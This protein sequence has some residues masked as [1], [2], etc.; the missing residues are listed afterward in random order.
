MRAWEAAKD[1]NLKY[2][3]G[4]EAYFVAD[5]TLSDDR[6]AH[7]ILLAKNMEGVCSINRALAEAN[8]TGFYRYP[9]VDIELLSKM[10]PRDVFVT[11][12]CVAH[13]GRVDKESGNLV[14]D[15]DAMRTFRFLAEHFTSSSLRLEVQAHNTAWQKEVNSLCQRLSYEYHIPLIAGLDSHYIFPEGFQERK[16]LRE[17]SGVHMKDEDHEIDAAVYEDYPDDATVIERFRQQGVLTEQEITS[18]MAATDELLEFEDIELSRDRK[19]PTVYPE[20][21]Q[22]ERNE[23]YL[24]RV[25]EGW[26]EYRKDIPEERWPEY[27]EAIRYETGIVT[28]TGVA[29]YFLITNDFVKLGVEKY[30]GIITP[31]GRGSSGGFFTNT[32]LGFSTLDRVDLPVKLY[33]ERFVTAERLKSSLPDLDL[34]MAA[35][36][37]FIAAMEE[38]MGKNHV[39]PMISYNTLKAKAAFKLYA[40]VSGLPADTAN[41]VSKQI[42]RYEMALKNAEEDEQD[43]IDIA[44]YVD[45]EYIPY[46]EKSEPYRGIVVS[47]S[48][49]PCG[50]LLY[51]GDIEADV[52]IVRVNTGKGKAV[53]CTVCDGYCLEAFGYVKE[54]CLVVNVLSVNAEAMRLAG[55]KPL[56]SKDVIR[57]VANDAP[58]WGV[59]AEG[60]TCGINQCGGASTTEKLKKYRPRELRDLAAFIAAIRPGFKSQLNSFLARERFSYHIAPFD[61]VLQNDSSGSSWMLYQENTMTALNLAGFSMERTYPIIKAI[62]KKKKK[63][64]DAA[65]EEFVLGFSDYVMRHVEN[66]DKSTADAQAR[67]TWRVIK[68][69]S[70]YSFN[71]CVTGDTVLKRPSNKHGVTLN[72]KDMYLIKNDAHYANATGHRALHDKYKRGGYGKG[73]S[74]FDD[75]RIREN[76]IVDIRQAG[77]RDVYCITLENGAS[78]KCT[79]NHKFPTPRGERHCGELKVGDLLYLCG[80]YEHDVFDSTLTDGSYEPNYPKKG[81]C[82]FREKTLGA[83]VLFK[84]FRDTAIQFSLPCAKCGKPYSDNDRFEVHHT[85]MDRHHNDFDNYTWLC[86]SCH[87]KIHYTS[88]RRK[89]GEKGYPS[90]TAT[91]TSIEYAGREMTYDVEMNAPAHNFTTANGIVTS[92]SHAVAVALDALYGAYLKAHYPVAY[93]TALLTNY[94]NKG[95]AEMIARIKQEMRSGFGIRMAPCRFRQDNRAYTF[96]AEKKTITD[97]LHAMKGVGPKVSDKLYAMRDIRFSTFVDALIYIRDKTSINSAVM[98]TLIRSGYFEEFGSTNRLLAVYAAFYD[99]DIH[100]DIKYVEKTKTARIAALKELERTA[101]DGEP[102]PLE[103]IRFEAEVYGAPY[104]VIDTP[105]TKLAYVVT[106]VQA[107]KGSP[108]LTLY[109][110]RT[111]STQVVKVRKDEFASMPLEVGDVMRPGSWKEKPQSR[112]VDGKW[113]PIP[114][115]REWWFYDYTKIS[116]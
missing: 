61:K 20:L 78:I 70:S 76:D 91:I 105:E 80:N 99:G 94:A 29:D 108:R 34:N 55:L 114:N 67:I 62:S 66:M 64:I 42:D 31:T 106:D 69:S 116:A 49:A 51:D 27:E 6:N 93:Y 98:N 60:Y 56:T 86:A 36:E 82:G 77:V 44:D 111:G 102:T 89:R 50:F 97:V 103:Q 12:A 45:A 24:E 104:S 112:M 101:E 71:A 92:N 110:I 9:R 14:M 26:E 35:Q 68:D 81:E 95:D 73:Y 53:Y 16:W 2:I 113:K 30:G 11:T 25:R 57:L 109:S 48:Q 13:W 88:G 85:D 72:I 59:F 10:S 54:D 40:R 38:V 4:V 33:P 100:Y 19:L 21:T 58:T 39:Y 74:L 75:G 8:R 84:R 43:A 107:K 41:E 17:D 47:R 79:D 32:L 52:G 115:T 18:S 96:D 46:V 87:K 5:R 63:V 3:F 83:S 1:Y 22:E 65:E 7:L 15:P 37:P 28:S 23:L 90:Y